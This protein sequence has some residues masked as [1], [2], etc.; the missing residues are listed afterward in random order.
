MEALRYCVCF[1]G[2]GSKMKDD[3]LRISG[4]AEESIVDGPGYR[5][6]IFTQGCPHRCPGCHNPQ[7][8]D[9]GGGTPANIKDL[10]VRIKANPL[11]KGVTFSGGEPFSQ[12]KPLAKLAAMAKAEGKDVFT[13]TGYIY[14][15]LLKGASK[16]NGW[17]ELL[18]ETD[19]LVDGPFLIKEKTLSLKFRGSKNQRII[20][21]RKSEKE[22]R[23]V[24]SDKF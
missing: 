21:I 14:E 4:I 19:F 11:L 15:D 17:A 10:F 3:F 1:G 5:F 13:Y 6:T 20:D 9:P 16:E 12:A 24:I 18:K 2:D 8:F 23:A 7:T 22:G